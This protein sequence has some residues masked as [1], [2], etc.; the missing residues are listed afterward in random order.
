MVTT[1][2]GRRAMWAQASLLLG[3]TLLVAMFSLWFLSS[4]GL[5]LRVSVS[6]SALLGAVAL[7]A[8]WAWWGARTF[9]GR[10]P[11]RVWALVIATSSGWPAVP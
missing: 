11:G 5:L 4:F 2:D 3:S 7:A 9:P 6:A 1:L 8:L 10:S